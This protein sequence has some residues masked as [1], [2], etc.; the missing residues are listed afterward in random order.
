MSL[1]KPAVVTSVGDIPKLVQHEISGLVVPPQ[2]PLA[3]ANAT[4]RLLREPDTASRL[5]NTAQQLYYNQYRPEIMT[6]RL[7]NLFAHLSQGN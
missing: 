2:D 6:R 4:L 5:G 3:L 7:E 1:G